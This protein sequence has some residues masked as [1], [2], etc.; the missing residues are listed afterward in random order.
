MSRERTLELGDVVI[1]YGISYTQLGNAFF[2][3]DIKPRDG[4]QRIDARRIAYADQ[5]HAIPFRRRKSRDV[6]DIGDT[7][8]RKAVVV[9]PVSAKHRIAHICQ[10][11]GQSRGVGD[12]M[13]GAIE[14]DDGRFPSGDARA[15]V[16]GKM[17]DFAG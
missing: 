6:V 11:C 13:E 2:L 14:F 3:T 1:A 12:I 8:D 9:A 5:I 4:Q 10:G 16:T 17:R 7:A 15:G